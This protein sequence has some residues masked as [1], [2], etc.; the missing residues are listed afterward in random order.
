MTI[1]NIEHRTVYRYTRPVHFGEHRVMCRPRDSHD[2]KLL[3]TSLTVSPPATSRWI[4]DVFGNSIALLNFADEAA[5]LSVVSTIRAEHFPAPPTAIAI[6]SYATQLPFSY[7]KDEVGD[8]ARTRDRHYDDPQHRVDE[9][10]RE[11]LNATPKRAT[12]DAL[13]NMAKRI[14]EEF[15]YARREDMGTQTPDKTLEL[16]TGSCRDFALLMMEAARSLGLAARSV[17]G[18]LYDPRLIGAKEGVVGTGATHAW[19]QV[20]LPGAGWVEYD[21]TNALIGG[22]NLIRVAVARDASQAAPLS[23][24][25]TGTIKDFIGMDVSVTVTAQ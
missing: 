10:A 6:D 2:L 5:E 19:V 15:R 13:V 4:H 8:L 14:K 7:S 24:S 22:S 12:L 17:S 16:G 3:D 18:Y 20:Y 21:P 1:L 23:G 9:W 11:V 25:F